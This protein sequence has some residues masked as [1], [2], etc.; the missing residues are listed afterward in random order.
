M[1]ISGQT[2]G[3]RLFIIAK[4]HYNGVSYNEG[5]LY[6]ANADIFVAVLPAVSPLTVNVFQRG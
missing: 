5:S 2:A 4:I 1:S 3:L 6:S